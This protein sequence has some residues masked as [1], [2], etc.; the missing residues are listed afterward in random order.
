MRSLFFV[1][2]CCI[3]LGKGRS[4]ADLNLFS[5]VIDNNNNDEDDGGSDILFPYQESGTGLSVEP[6]L[7]WD[8][9]DDPNDSFLADTSITI[10]DC[11]SESLEPVGKLKLRAREGGPVCETQKPQ[12]KKSNAPFWQLKDDLHDGGNDLTLTLEEFSCNVHGYQYVVCDSGTM[13]DFEPLVLNLFTLEYCDLCKLPPGQS[14]SS[15]CFSSTCLK[16][17]WRYS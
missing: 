8:L 3:F 6:T 15:I 2:L 17:F 5:G 1:T 4:R 7:P 9:Y 14:L 11:S 13:N 12:Q 16:F 10:D